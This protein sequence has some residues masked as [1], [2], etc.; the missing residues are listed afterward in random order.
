MEFDGRKEKQVRV[1][2]KS[3]L[4]LTQLYKIGL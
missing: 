2:L 4:G 3:G 1:F